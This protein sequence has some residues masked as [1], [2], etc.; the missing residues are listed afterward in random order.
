MKP[1]NSAFSA[2]T[3][4]LQLV[5]DAS[6][7]KAYQFCP[8]YYEINN[9]QGWHGSSVDLEFG[10]LIASGFEMFKKARLNGK[11]IEDALVAV[12]TWV[13]NETW[14]PATDTDPADRQWGGRYE[15]M[16]KCTGERPY[17]NAKGNRAK[18]PFAHERAWFDGEA[19]D[20]CGECGSPT[21]SERRYLPNSPAKNRLTLVRT[22]IWYGLSQPENLDDGLKPYVFP[23]GRPAVELSGKLPLPF[24][25]MDG[26]GY[27]M[28]YNFDYIGDYGGERFIVDNKTTSKPLTEQY[29]ASFAPDTQFDTYDLIAST[30][31]PDLNIRG[32][33]VEGVKVT[34][35]ESEFGLRPYYK[36]NEYRE[37]HLNDIGS[38]LADAERSA[39]TGYYRMNKRNCWICPLKAVCSLAPK[40]RD[41]YMQSNMTREAPWNPARE[42]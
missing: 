34:A 3:P 21:R 14:M 6:S 19:P 40:M 13:M 38:W 39:R 12:V 27:V 23:D 15:T 18:C 1:I 32:T 20:I 35:T 2:K 4:N 31:F 7:L 10:R 22:L 42:R 11:S 9:L 25:T 36:T 37:E 26:E 16:W 8:R 17:K 29:F 41:G 30:V 33:M 28:A 24:K 5:W